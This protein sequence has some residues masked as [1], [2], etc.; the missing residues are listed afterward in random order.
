MS[1]L[2]EFSGNALQ[3][4]ISDS[5]FGV[6]SYQQLRLLVR[7]AAQKFRRRE[8]VGI[9]CR[10][11][12]TAV[13]N[14]LA[15]LEAG[16]VPLML[17]SSLHHSVHADLLREFSCGNLFEADEGKWLQRGASPQLHDS[18]ALLLSTSGSSGKPKLVRLSWGNLLSNARSIASYLR[19]GEKDRGITSLPIHYSYGLSILH[20]HLVAGASVVLT[21][22]SVASASFWD[23]FREFSV[24]S[25]AGVPATWRI[26]RRMRFE[27]MPLPCLNT[28]TQAGGRMEREELEWLA[29]LAER[30]GWRFFSMYG[31]TEATAR[32]SFVPAECAVRK[33]GSI[34]QAIPGGRMWLRSECG[35]P[36]RASGVE[37]EI[38]YEGPN[39]MMGYAESPE[40]LALGE[41]L[42]QLETGDMATLDEDGYFWISGRRSRYIKIN[43]RR[44]GL[45][46][47]ERILRGAS[48]P[49]VACGQDDRLVIAVE[50]DYVEEELLE[51]LMRHFGIL[52]R[53]CFI[54]KVESIPYSASGKVLYPELLRR[55]P[56]ISQD[57]TVC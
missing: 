39:V 5:S 57:N 49:A 51:L 1:I 46:P 26:L 42:S 55:A 32:I 4:A 6:C 30:M 24:T 31:Q 47:V 15:L 45:E 38:I 56:T 7:D 40:D 41:G 44:I 27:R 9:I 53:N 50:G 11:S 28:L 20:S 19:I 18:L 36:I 14:Y 21:G 33:A 3:P 43:G 13:V 12:V 10:N 34:G 8:L 52:A 35:E 17:D 54:F 37:G 16:A 29:G 23:I 2:A 22:E 48:C 25:L